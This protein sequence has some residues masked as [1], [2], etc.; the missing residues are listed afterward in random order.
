MKNS[1]FAAL[2]AQI[3]R[4]RANLENVFPQH[5][6]KRDS[7]A[8]DFDAMSYALKPVRRMYFTWIDKE[9][10]SSYESTLKA[11]AARRATI[12][13]A[14]QNA[15]DGIKRAASGNGNGV[16]V[17]PVLAGVDF[18]SLRSATYWTF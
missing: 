12:Q 13:Q 15:K 9:D 7:D 4:D 11:D 5:R 2:A 14:K 8:I 16:Q 18:L 1:N 10:P 3:Q 17:E 6:R